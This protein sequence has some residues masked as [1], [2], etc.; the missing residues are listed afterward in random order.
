MDAVVVDSRPRAGRALFGCLVTSE[1]GGKM[2]RPGTGSSREV[3]VGL[4]FCL[5]FFAQGFGFTSSCF[6]RSSPAVQ[7]RDEKHII[8]VLE[9]VIQL[10]LQAKKKNEKWFKCHFQILAAKRK[11]L[12]KRW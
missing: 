8:L 10:T 1:R 11:Q 7:C 4:G 5:G 6:S 2:Q 12:I 9:F 3:W